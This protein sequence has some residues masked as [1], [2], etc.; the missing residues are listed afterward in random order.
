MQRQ[1]PH[2]D[3]NWVIVFKK[4]FVGVSLIYNIVFISGVHEMN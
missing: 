1:R 4:I 2:S 3:Q